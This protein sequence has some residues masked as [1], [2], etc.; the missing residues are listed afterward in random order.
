MTT[1]AVVPALMPPRT[2]R[3][4]ASHRTGVRLELTRRGKA[5]RSLL[6]LIALLV[7]VTAATLWSGA[8]SAFAEWAGGGQFVSVTVQPG[9]TLWEYA[10]TY[11]PPGS[12]PRDY[13]LQ[14]QQ[15]NDLTGTRVTAGTQL[16]LPVGRG[17]AH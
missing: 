13:V 14:I 10:R 2:R 16:D 8:S 11:G 4:G 5:V 7:T 9:D 15:A 3:R 12:D 17:A 6:V 1:I